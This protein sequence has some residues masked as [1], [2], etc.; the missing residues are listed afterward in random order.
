MH[1]RWAAVFS[2]TLLVTAATALALTALVWV[3]PASAQSRSVVWQ[4]WDVLIDNVDTAAN[5]FDVTETHDVHFSGTFRFGSRVIETDRLDDISNIRVS[6]GKTVYREGCSEQPATYCVSNTNDGRSIT[7]YFAQPITDGSDV[8]TIQYTV[9]GAL[10]SYPDGDQLWWSI[11]PEEHYGFPI[12]ASSTTAQMPAGFGP[13][14]AVDPVVTYGWP[15]QVDVRGTTVSVTTQGQVSGNGSLELRVQYPHN[16][17]MFAPGWQSMFDVQRSFE[18]GAKP[19]IDLGLIV[20]G[21]VIGLGGPLGMYYLWYTRGRDP[22]I[23]PVPEYLSEPPSDLPPALIGTLVDEKADL[24]DVMS[25]IIDLARRGYVVI[26][27][28]QNEGVFGF[29]RSSEFTF[30]RTDKATDDLYSFERRIMD[31]IFSG[32]KMERSM[33]SMKNTFYT[34]IPLIQN[35]LNE[36]M[37]TNGL[38]KEKPTTTRGKWTGGGILLIVLA[39]FGGVAAV[40][41]IEGLTPALL[42]IPAA[43][44]FA[45][46]IMAS[47]GNYM[48]VKTHK[49]AEE[50]AKWNAFREYLQNL[51]KYGNVEE[52]KTRFD[53]YL[54]YAVAY[55]LDRT[56]I[57]RFSKL[58]DM[59]IP[60]WYYPTYVGGPWGRGYRAGTPVGHFGGGFGTGGS[61]VPG[62]LARADDGGFSFDNMSGNLTAG[63]NN[64]SNGLTQMLNSA[65]STFTSRPQSASS[66]SSGSWS[67]G[68]SSFSGGGFSGGGSSG[69]GSAG[70][71]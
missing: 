37:V 43:V 34:E 25:T 39:V 18:E 10:R 41:G 31:K 50:A 7:Y 69:G 9:D 2:V 35:D 11:I 71:G 32:G 24:R 30:K 36:L 68:G 5:Q 56:W 42:C 58:D 63:L 14:E 66:G 26:E 57:Q 19:L 47:V 1:K 62:G 15:A 45:G 33:D 16:P 52:A 59:P 44:G 17:A 12:N 20:L 40:A 6:Q 51:E 8:F 48:P 60:I 67:S 53:Q 21:L 4:H 28:T 27:E 22:Q 65:S 70:F 3:T 55:G 64:M 38:M 23:G 13:R 29:G 49:G 46:I 54:A 61:G